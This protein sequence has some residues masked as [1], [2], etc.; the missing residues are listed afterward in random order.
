MMNP[1]EDY[2]AA[3]KRTVTLLLM[4]AYSFNAM[5]RS[6]IAILGQSIKVDLK[7]TDTQ[8]GLLTGT[9]FALFYA[10][11]GIP[12]ARLAERFNRVNIIAAAM[13]VWSTL[14]ALCGAATAFPQLLCIRVG[15]GIA[16]S[17]CSPPAHSLLSDYFP[18]SART[19]ALSVYSCGT[20]I[21]YLLAAVIGGYVVQHSGW[22]AAC[23]IVGLPGIAIAMLIKAVIR[24]PRRDRAA[25]G[26]AG[27]V[28]REWSLRRELREL[29]AVAAS[30]LTRRPV[31][32]MILGVTIGGFAAYGFYAFMPAYLTRAFGLAYG[33]AGV[34][35]GIAGGVAVGFGIM[36]GGTLAD[37]LAK[38]DARWYALVPA[39]GAA[40]AVPIFAL[41]LVAADWRLCVCL[42]AAAGFLF[43]TSLGPTFGVVQN[44]VG[45][46][47]RATATA[48][49]YICL[50][51]FALGGGPL[52]AGWAMD[53]FADAEFHRA[54][55]E[56]SSTYKTGCPGGRALPA[57][58]AAL[59]TLC[60]ATSARSTRAGLLVTLIFFAWGGWH[61]FLASLG[62]AK[63]LREAAHGSAAQDS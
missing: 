62:I 2:S 33:L 37:R 35:A 41:A 21:G 12:I 30:L 24:E 48:F 19:S 52:F 39:L 56:A 22:R 13:V 60:A 20:S 40:A 49:L 11:G 44:V 42:L 23:A 6:I 27:A 61:Y 59:A 28:P 25:G 38:H 26:R 29:G 31:L 7:L 32:H 46:G 63:S 9:A 18:P 4:T 58:P 57:S 16:E 10:F 36:A 5:D 50:S 14:S 34:S 15:V 17:G 45:A 54:G 1:A 47:Q 43:Y 3:Y 55:G 53:R 51:V 8:L